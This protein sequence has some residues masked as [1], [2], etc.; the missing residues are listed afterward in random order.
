MMQRALADAQAGADFRIQQIR[1]VGINELSKLKDAKLLTPE[2][3]RLHRRAVE[4]KPTQ[5]LTDNPLELARLDPIN[6]LPKG[7]ARDSALRIRAAKDRL[8]GDEQFAG[9]GTKELGDVYAAYARRGKVFFDQPAEI[10][11]AMRGLKPVHSSQIQRE[12]FLRNWPDGSETINQITLDRKLSG[13]AI[14][15]G[16]GPTLSPATRRIFEGQWKKGYKVSS[17]EARDTVRELFPATTSR[18]MDID[19]GIEHLLNTYGNKLPAH[20]QTPEELR[21]FVTWLSELDP[22]HVTTG[23][24]VFGHHPAFDALNREVFSAQAVSAANVIYG[25]AG[26][27]A[28]HAKE[29]IVG[30]PQTSLF[31]L[32]KDAKMTGSG[33][34]DRM[35]EHLP[36]SLRD[37]FAKKGEGVLQGPFSK[38]TALKNIY[39]PKDTADNL[40][41]LGRTLHDPAT[42]ETVETALGQFWDSWINLFKGH[43]TAYWPAFISRNLISG[44]FQNQIGRAYSLNPFARDGMWSSLNDIKETMRGRDIPNVLEIPLVKAAGITDPHEGTR[45]VLSKLAAGHLG[46]MRQLE[47]AGGGLEAIARGT[48]DLL[49]GMVWGP[50][51][52]LLGK[53]FRWRDLFTLWQSRGVGTGFMG[54]GPKRE[55]AEH[56]LGRFGED[57]GLVVETL[58]R[59]APALA[60][61]RR[62]I[63]PAEAIKR[64]KLLQ[65]DYMAQGVGDKHL[66][67]AIPFFTFL[68]G[69]TK[70]MAEELSQR[71]GGPLAQ[72]IRTESALQ[73]Q[74][75]PDAIPEHVRK[76]AAIPFGTTPEGG[77][78]ILTS[79]GFMH[80]DPLQFLGGVVDRGP[81]KALTSIPLTA[82]R[83][84]GSRLAPQI[85]TPIELLTG[86]S[87]WQAGPRGGRALVD[88]Y[89]HLGGLAG[90]ALGRPVKLP[91]AVE[92]LPQLLGAGRWLS[93]AGKLADERKTWK[94]T[95][96]NLLTGAHLTTVSPG[97]QAKVI[98]ESIEQTMTDMGARH[99]DYT[100]FPK[101][102]TEKMSP[103]EQVKRKN[104]QLLQRALQR[105]QR[106]ARQ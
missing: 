9:L 47:T 54:T 105:K 81:M 76:T 97:Q 87:T 8:L 79:L 4:W 6:Q 71:P 25:L 61:L 68:K 73:R 22:Q 49:A 5:E 44:Q 37:R 11:A 45:L 53:E 35:M 52:Q 86:A 91:S 26:R 16:I 24:P 102:E 19:A 59:F 32:L 15:E 65:V 56:L 94:Q 21:G 46:G 34:Y 77:A 20:M 29:V 89:G 90:K 98:E 93:T 30:K 85:A 43:V 101:W 100:Y 50:K 60:M 57:A 64:V 38:E 41:G 48:D 70:F 13:K 10:A 66:R 3:I 67:R 51:S 23:I 31:D 17:E 83:E 80:E 84:A 39:I 1:E 36:E 104:L 92:Q 58:N 72:I 106:M 96:L 74:G 55:V 33:A 12:E 95:A 42:L 99:G 18:G 63:D 88:Q 27:S 7:V 69:V 78:N 75:L 14:R 62:G 103:E 82:L 40:I 2:Q 28:R